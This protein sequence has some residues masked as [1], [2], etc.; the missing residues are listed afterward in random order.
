[1]HVIL[2]G[3]FGVLHEVA[4]I[5]NDSKIRSEAKSLAQN[6]LGDFEF[7]VSM[8]VWVNFFFERYRETGFLDAT[9]SAKKIATD[10]NIDPVFPRR[11]EIRRKKHFDE[12]PSDASEI[13]K[14]SAE[15]SFRVNYFLSLVDHAIAS[16]GKRFE[17]YQDYESVQDQLDVDGNDLYVE[18][19][20][21]QDYLPNENMGPVD[22]LNYLKHVECFPNA[23]IAYT[24]LLIIPV[25]VASAERSFSKLKL[26]KSYLR[27]TMTQDRLNGL[28]LI[29]IENGFL[30]KVDYKELVE[31]FVSKNV[32]RMILFK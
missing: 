32:K 8:V 6:E 14:Q 7:L 20:L 30:D 29:A 28:A 5:D 15:E 25:T 9:E 12:N 17:Q 1:M 26:L 3:N 4:E 11:R 21:L 31:D 2:F 18:L 22:I 27:S 10:L 19:R 23:I 16:L 13:T 24:V